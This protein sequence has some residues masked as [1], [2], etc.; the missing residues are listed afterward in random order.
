MAIQ[1][2]GE[3][4]QIEHVLQ[5]ARH[6]EKIE[7]H[8]EARKRIAHCRGFVDKKIEERAIMYGITTGIGELSEVILTPEQVERFQRF[9]VYSHA[10]GFQG[11]DD[12]FFGAKQQTCP[13]GR[14][15]FH[16]A[17]LSELHLFQ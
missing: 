16:N 5:I 7:I 12:Q 2:D 1:V 17:G 9:L 11:A 8:P 10:A 14:A 13:G 4:L 15:F 3:H 6:G